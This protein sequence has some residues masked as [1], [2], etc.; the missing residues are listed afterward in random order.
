MDAALLQVRDDS[1]RPVSRRLF[2]VT[3]RQ[4]D[5]ACRREAFGDEG[6]DG[7]EDRDKRSFV[8][9]RAAG[10]EFG[11]LALTHDLGAERRMLPLRLDHGHDIHVGHEHERIFG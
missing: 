6:L 1:P 10:V 7:F 11:I 5:V 3:E 9:D 8:V 2:V 4:V